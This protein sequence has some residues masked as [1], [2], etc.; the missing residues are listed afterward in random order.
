MASIIH[1]LWW[2]AEM[3]TDWFSR[4]LSNWAKNYQWPSFILFSLFQVSKHQHQ[5][6]RRSSS[7]ISKDLGSSFVPL[8]LSLSLSFSSLTFYP[9][10]ARS[11]KQINMTSNGDEKQTGVKIWPEAKQRLIRVFNC[12][13]EGLV[14]STKKP[15]GYSSALSSH[16]YR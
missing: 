13:L 10:L 7:G 11:E 2:S 1:P 5:R 8:S 16:N 12:S 15:Y 6:H 14:L 4:W 9:S 3:S